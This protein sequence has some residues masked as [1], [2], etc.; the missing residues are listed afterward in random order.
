MKKSF[1]I[2]NVGEWVRIFPAFVF[3]M[4]SVISLKANTGEYKTPDFAFPRS[5]EQSADSLLHVSLKD[6]DGL[7]ALRATLNLTL[8]RNQLTDAESVAPNLVL[9]DSVIGRI[10]QP[11]KSIGLL[12][13]AQILNNLYSLDKYTF[14]S[15]NLPLNMPFPSDPTEWSGG[16]F[17]HKIYELVD[18]AANGIN[19][20]KPENIGKIS[21][22]LNDF[23][24]AEV[25]GL[26]I[27]EFIAFKSADILK[28]F[29][30]ERAATL[31]PFFP[32][33]Q[34]KTIEGKS[35]KKALELLSLI[36]NDFA[37]NNSVIQSA[38]IRASIP[39]KSDAEQEQF[40]IN[41][42]EKLRNTEGEG[43][44][45]YELWNR[46]GYSQ[47]K[48]YDAIVSWLKKYPQGYGSNLL[49]NAKKE[50]ERQQI[51]VEFPKT[52]LPGTDISGKITVSNIDK[53]YFL[54]YKLSTDQ[55]N[56]YD[57]LI[58]KKFTGTGNPVKV[59][60]FENPGQVP[61]RFDKNVNL[62]ELSEGIYTVIPSMSPKLPAGWNKTNS[63]ANYS[64]VRVS[65]IALITSFDSGIK[66]SG[67]V[68]VVKGANQQP[69]KGAVV[70]YY[71]GN[72]KT[73]KGTLITN[74]EGYVRMPNGYFRI[75]ATYGQS[76]ARSEG[77]FSYYPQ[78]V[79][80]S[81][82]AS[83]LT[84]LEVYRPGDTI[85][86]ALVGWK[87]D[88]YQ[89]SLVK[90]CNIEVNLIDPN[91]KTAG[92]SILRLNEE[93]RSSSEI[94]IPSGRLLGTYSLIANFSDPEYK[95]SGSCTILVQEYKLPGFFVSM[96]QKDAENDSYVSFEGI[97][98]TYSG[99]PVNNAKV[100]I[101]VEY[102][103][104][105]WG[106]FG[107]NAS[108]FTDTITDSEGNFSLV[109]PLDELKNTPYSRGRFSI[110]AEVTSEAGET[111]KSN[112]LYFYLGKGYDIRPAIPDK[113]EVVNDTI[114]FNVPVYDMAGLPQKTEVDFSI[115]N[116]ASP[117]DTI[118]GY[119]TS[120][121]LDLESTSLPSGRYR[122]IFK[123]KDSDSPVTTETVIWRKDDIKAPFP[124]PL[125]VPETELQYDTEEKSID[126]I[127]GSYWEDWILCV[128][129]DGEKIIRN[130]WLEPRSDLHH[131]TIDIPDGNPTLFVSLSGMHDLESETNQITI[132]SKKSLEK[133]T[134]T[135]SSFRDKITSGD[136]EQWTF[137]F[138]I[139]ENAP[140]NV[141]VFAVMTDKALNAIQDFKWGLN[142]WKPGI[143]NK[144]R[145][146]PQ[147]EGS[148]V[149]YKIFSGYNNVSIDWHK[150]N[151]IPGWQT[152]GY[153][154]V[155]YSSFRTGGV[156]LYKAMATRNAM[157][158]KMSATMVTE[159][160][161]Y[162]DAE[163]E[164]PQESGIIPSEE[165]K[166]EEQLRPVEMPVALFLPNLKANE[167]GEI[168]I[169][170]T[171]PN[172]NT[173][174][175]FQ[176]AAYTPDLLN[177]TLVL[178]AV[179]TKPV[180]VKSNL[181]QFLRT[182]DVAYI[183]STIFNNTNENLPL[184]GKIRVINP[185][186]GE[187]LVSHDAAQEIVEPS[188]NRVITVSF[189][190]GDD[191]PGLIV[192]SYGIS[193]SSSDGEQGFVPVLPSSTPVTES[194]V[195][196]AK[197]SQDSIELT[198]PKLNKEANVT[199]KY[200]DNPLWDVILSLP[201]LENSES[202]GALAVASNLFATILSSDIINKNENIAS[203]IVD[204]VSS[205]DSTISMSPLQKDSSLKIA[206]LYAT[207]WVNDA[208]SETS[209][210]RSLVKYLDR[211]KVENLIT[212]NIQHLSRLQ[213]PDGGWSWWE[214]MKSSPYITSQVISIMG[215]LNQK[216]LLNAEMKKMSQKAVKYYDGVLVEEKSQNKKNSPVSVINYL[217]YRNML[218]YSMDNGMKRIEKEV[219][220]SAV[221][222]WRRWDISSKAKAAMVFMNKEKYK[223]EASTI[224][225]SLK[226]FL[227]KKVDLQ[228][229][230]LLLELFYKME[231][232]SEIVEQL[233]ESLFLKKETQD[234]GKDL[235]AAGVIYTLLQTS[236][237][238]QVHRKAPEVFINGKL[239]P[240]SSTQSLTGNYT[241]NLDPSDIAGK[242]LVIKRE[243]GL[244]AWGGI[245]S[246]WIQPIVEVK[247]KS[248]RDLEVEKHLYIEDSKGNV[249]EVKSFRQ[250]DKIK[251]VLNI[252][253]R[254]DMD[255][256]VI[257]DS[258][259][260]CLQPDNQVSGIVNVDGITS[261]REIRKDKTS[262]FIENLRS[263]NYVISYDCHADRCG[264][265]SLGIAEVQS[266]YSPAQV[267]HSSGKAIE[268]SN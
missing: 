75:E 130:E 128:V 163:V 10:S 66:D 1:N 253:C 265:Y 53:G 182:G 222:Q 110:T 48:D 153:P 108:Y 129:S 191:L 70:K 174:W 159:E 71:S 68:Y 219:L 266:L 126:V 117:S 57:N 234:W 118:K 179:A 168:T 254:K 209:R 140:E 249:K 58:L 113:T 202:G 144:V 60:E 152:Y 45:L 231:A 247:N 34:Q 40:L 22:L 13:E 43:V 90:N 61:F 17:R 47:K 74:S 227:G 203:G 217:Y 146:F 262:F 142:I 176:L 119:F 248:V 214:G 93:G 94:M 186:N 37:R 112:P 189:K 157:A 192:K 29:T 55:Y 155:S 15:R 196:Y 92:T 257:A 136:K 25:Y 38:A 63:S 212:N 104:W 216:G 252:T 141:N 139:G 96:N 225:S 125:W 51:D 44:I 27:P 245:I 67:R 82:H 86:F 232:G 188:G 213:Q 148:G 121:T 223:D 164:A 178:D 87:Q 77:G 103:P 177:T 133:L 50:I 137:R 171:V 243:D 193:E 156:Y 194:T 162:D 84:D 167:D 122:L 56:Q 263:G 211:E 161:A 170:F 54:I 14:D 184:G 52:A 78:S 26:T 147:R 35:L 238:I 102:L 143:Y 256:V 230:A 127:F 229:D 154:L 151:L 166:E 169:D 2:R 195:F 89:N 172:F 145:L 18:S 99:M 5:V 28:D 175:Q 76:M 197:S 85:K 181:P 160:A 79:K 114:S 88:K 6:G 134:V 244:P 239:L 12:L 16:M 226:E 98:K 206:N 149:S 65:E 91:G 41:N 158:D 19:F 132:V 220:D 173:T 8:A 64:T 3:T 109:L 264:I 228:Q 242:K 251:V 80:T 150:L 236:S 73:P 42:L 201:A 124:T 210:I 69:L 72:D 131:L 106:Y 246:Q 183:S 208:E 33:Q 138:N 116:L 261:Y 207:P 267:A 205:E 39:L 185:N 235:M 268:I 101:K 46:Y 204:I 100:N 20:M 21:V 190:V 221:S 36:E 7:M 59:I 31:I 11:Y 62:G 49:E 240:L 95:G 255:Y 218:G 260:A 4:L 180:M 97:A 111:E 32:A 187:V 30:N 135:A 105:R 165:L 115:I 9:L 123:T 24:S 233:R 199:L 107:N 120:P 237:P 241:F 83:I 198:L 250:G 258:R 224:V 23:T 200:C 215:Y 259:S 81:F